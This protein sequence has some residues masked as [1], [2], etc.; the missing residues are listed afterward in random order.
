LQPIDFGGA[1]LLNQVTALCL[2]FGVERDGLAAL[3][4][5]V[6]LLA[7]YG[8]VGG[9]FDAQPHLVAP[10]I[11]DSDNYVVTDYNLLSA[12]TG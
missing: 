5:F 12:V 4:I 6:H 8:D 7:M 11:D 3:D 10:D 2:Q 1:D 9:G